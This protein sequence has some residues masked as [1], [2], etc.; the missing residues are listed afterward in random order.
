M[1]RYLTKNEL[2]EPK[3]IFNDWVK[4]VQKELKKEKRI[5]FSFDPIGSGK[6]N[7]VVWQCNRDSF[8]LDY[9]ITLT[10]LPEDLAK[11]L[12]KK[13]KDINQIFKDA[14]DYYR[15]GGFG[16]CDDSTQALTTLNVDKHFGYDVI[17]TYRDS[18]GTLHILYNKKNTNGANNKDYWWA[19][20]ADMS[21]HRE[22]YLKVVK[23][24]HRK[25]LKDLYLKKRHA[26]KDDVE[27][28]K[29]KS[30]QIL[31]EAVNEIIEKYNIK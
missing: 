11:N 6:R 24:K 8:D 14:F 17:I 29:K 10:K 12:S 13:A 26:H 5:H 9:Q 3:K 18:E 20:K 1:C 21:N 30:Y 28:N 22:N 19:P 23:S 15:P 31:N 2:K 25:Q 4:K 27:P 7:M 16:Y